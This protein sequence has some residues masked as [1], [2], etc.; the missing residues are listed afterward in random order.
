MR[1]FRAIDG[2]NPCNIILVEVMGKIQGRSGITPE[3]VVKTTT[4]K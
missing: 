2:L 3:V 4:G 1:W